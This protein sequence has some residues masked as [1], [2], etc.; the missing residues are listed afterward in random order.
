MKI[1]QIQCVSVPQGNVFLYALGEDGKIY[2]TRDHDNK[3][4]EV[5]F[6]IEQGVKR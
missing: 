4:Q 6:I 1:K 3:W 5:P 2:F